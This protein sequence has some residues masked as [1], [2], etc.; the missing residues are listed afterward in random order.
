MRPPKQFF[1]YIMTNGPKPAILYTG[2]TGN[3]R[4]RVWQHKD[5]LIPGFTSRYNLTRL[6]Y[7]ECFFYP[8]AATRLVYYE[9]F[10]Y[11]DAAIN[12][13][14]EIKA[15]RRSKKIKLIESI[16]PK[17]EDLAQGWQDQYKP[18]AAVCREIPRSA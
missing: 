7:Y 15:W 4:R 11:P 12:R 13:E 1:V 8:D 5:K 9:C 16:N 2:V 18:D 17:W 6:V 10:F 3:L 14:K